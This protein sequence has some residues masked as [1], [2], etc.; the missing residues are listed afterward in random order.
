MIELLAQTE[1]SW[2]KFLETQSPL[3]V[4]YSLVIAGMIWAAR[5]LAKYGPSIIEKHI[6]FVEVATDSLSKSADAIKSVQTEVA[7][8]RGIVLGGKKNLSAASKP[9]CEALIE[10][11]PTE[12]KNKVREHLSEVQHI[13]NRE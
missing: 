1:F 8:N 13:L 4:I 12:S 3:W 11:A 6:E 5:A 2:S 7:I 9:F 10:M